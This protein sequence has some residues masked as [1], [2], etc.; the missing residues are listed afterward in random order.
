[1]KTEI[2]WRRG[3]AAWALGGALLSLALGAHATFNPPI[4]MANGVE[5]MSGG[6][7]SDE[8]ALM[9]TVE[10]RWPAAFEFAVK[11][12]RDADF[13]ANVQI[14]VRDGSGKVVLGQV[15]A[16]GPFMVARL[17]PGHYDVEA[18]LDGKTLTKAIDVRAGDSARAMF[19][20]PAG[21]DMSA[22]S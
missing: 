16:E 2:S 8:A 10:P 7:G 15:K 1:M 14:T 4:H 19:V 3:A 12:G 20:W 17:E 22:H 6:I 13:A 11:D 18:T 5:Y 9:K 21:S